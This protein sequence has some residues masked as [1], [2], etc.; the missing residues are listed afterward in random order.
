MEINIPDGVV[1]FSEKQER[2]WV[3]QPTLCF[4]HAVLRALKG[5]QIKVELNSNRADFNWH[6]DDC[7]ND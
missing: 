7:S 1:F 2:D 5:E 3:A 6:C 4:R